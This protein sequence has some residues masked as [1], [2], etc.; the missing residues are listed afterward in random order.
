V[1][2]RAVIS[3]LEFQERGVERGELVAGGH[4]GSSSRFVVTLHAATLSAIGGSSL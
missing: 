1:H 4:N 2:Q 3:L